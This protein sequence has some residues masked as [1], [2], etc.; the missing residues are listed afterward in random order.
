MHGGSFN[1]LQF[2]AL[3]NSRVLAALRIGRGPKAYHNAYYVKYM[4]GLDWPQNV[5]GQI[6]PTLAA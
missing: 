2:E 4:M 1:F 3:P 6:E 5:I